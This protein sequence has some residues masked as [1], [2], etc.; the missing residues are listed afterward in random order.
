MSTKPKRKRSRS[1][2]KTE[3]WK[4]DIY[5]RPCERGIAVAKQPMKDLTAVLKLKPGH[6]Y[7]IEMTVRVKRDVTAKWEGLDAPA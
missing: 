7:E 3:I 2:L 5:V 4:G 6:Y 1:I